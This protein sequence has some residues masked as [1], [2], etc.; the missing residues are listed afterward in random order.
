MAGTRSDSWTAL[1]G[2]CRDRALRSCSSRDPP[3]AIETGLRD[4]PRLIGGAT[5]IDP[6]RSTTWTGHSAGS[7]P[8]ASGG[9]LI[10]IAASCRSRRAG[11]LALVGNAV[12]AR[13][14]DRVS[15]A[16][17]GSGPSPFGVRIAPGTRG[18]RRSLPRSLIGASFAGCCSMRLKRCRTRERPSALRLASGS[19]TSRSAHGRL[20]APM[21]GP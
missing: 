21:G 9:A 12:V 3:L 16:A 17:G 13:P 10:C 5:T 8:A 4:R 19:F 14:R 6:E 20:R 7:R 18:C 1:R 2:S 15:R 11:V